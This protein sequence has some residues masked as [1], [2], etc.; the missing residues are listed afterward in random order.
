MGGRIVTPKDIEGQLN[1][2]KRIIARDAKLGNASPLSVIEVKKMAQKV[3][4]ALEFHKQ[5]EKLKGQMEIAYQKR[6][7]LMPSVKEMIRKSRN[8]LKGVH[9][10]D[11]KA[12]HHYGFSVDDTPRKKKTN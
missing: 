2:S 3:D 11:L 12:L 6:D 10:K 8:I 4:K 9:L 1:L 7:N 5:A